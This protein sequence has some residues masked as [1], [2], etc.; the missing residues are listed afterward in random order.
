MS[1]KLTWKSSE[2]TAPYHDMISMRNK[3]IMDF[4]ALRNIHYIHLKKLVVLELC[5]DE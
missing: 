1:G 5:A 2:S 4:S 3:V